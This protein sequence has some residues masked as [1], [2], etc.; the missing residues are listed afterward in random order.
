M[1]GLN[2]VF[3]GMR[4]LAKVTKVYWSITLHH[5]TWLSVA[6]QISP[7]DITKQ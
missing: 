6:L 7:G 3:I 1:V 2:F 4:T 5:I